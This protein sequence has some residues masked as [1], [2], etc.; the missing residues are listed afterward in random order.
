M[1]Y[2]S[3]PIAV[4]AAVFGLPVIDFSKPTNGLCTRKKSRIECSPSPVR[5]VIARHGK[6]VGGDVGA[7]L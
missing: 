2:I 4:R 3:R 7:L 1:G 5:P 6:V